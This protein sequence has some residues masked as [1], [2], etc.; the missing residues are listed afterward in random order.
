[1]YVSFIAVHFLYELCVWAR[2]MNHLKRLATGIKTRIASEW[3]LVPIRRRNRN[4]TETNTAN[5]TGSESLTKSQKR[6]R[7]RR[8]AKRRAKQKAKQQKELRE[9][10]LQINHP[11]EDSVIARNKIDRLTLLKHASHMLNMYKQIGSR[12]IVEMSPD[13][14]IH[15]WS[16]PPSFFMVDADPHTSEIFY[17]LFLPSRSQN[18][19]SGKI[20]CI[21][22]ISG[23]I[24][25]LCTLQGF[26]YLI[27]ANT[28]M[29][30]VLRDVLSSVL[31]VIP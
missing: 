20:T 31:N 3:Q 6:N 7:A 17:R 12:G 23:Y 13:G 30:V 8:R 24:Y 4:S 15:A 29:R 16:N 27:R 2:C 11:R 22:H 9:S 10:V 14:R 1:M 26:I 28:T 5:Q 21:Y 19:C 18:F 25:L